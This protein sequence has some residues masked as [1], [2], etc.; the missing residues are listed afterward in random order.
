MNLFTPKD[1]STYVKNEFDHMQSQVSPFMKRSMIYSFIA[2][3]L[4]AISV[5]NL[6]FVI[7]SMSLTSDSALVIGGLALIGAIGM[8]LFKESVHNNKSLHQ[9]SLEYVKSRIKKSEIIP[10]HAIDRYLKNIENSPNRLFQTFHDFLQ[11]E[12]RLKNHE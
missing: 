8:A 4:I 9:T 3:P 1:A 12:E 2:F 5:F 7:S 6:F 11:H 10:E